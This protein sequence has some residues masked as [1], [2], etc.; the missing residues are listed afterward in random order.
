MN[1]SELMLRLQLAGEDKK[2]ERLAA[3]IIERYEEDL[4]FDDPAV[5]YNGKCGNCGYTFQEGDCQ[6]DGIK[7]IVA[8]D[9]CY[10]EL[11]RPITLADLED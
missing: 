7:N 9:S 2:A 5:K 8:C 3:L 11:T 4:R 6:H 1:A 10:M